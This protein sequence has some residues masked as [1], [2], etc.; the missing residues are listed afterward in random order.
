MRE[1]AFFASRVESVR[2]P[3][4]IE[5]WL[6]DFL[7]GAREK[8]TLPDGTETTRL[9]IGSRGDFIKEVQDFGIQQRMRPLDPDQEGTV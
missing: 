7:S 1:R 5:T 9:K 6:N 2:F 3:R 8:V 4:T